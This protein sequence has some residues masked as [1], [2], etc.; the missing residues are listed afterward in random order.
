MAAGPP[1]PVAGAPAGPPLNP[2]VA[3]LLQQQAQA[4]Q[5]RVP[6]Y[7][8]GGA[9]VIEDTEGFSPRAKAKRVR[10]FSD[11]GKP[12]EDLP[13]VE[14]KAKGGSIKKRRPTGK[15]KLGKGEKLPVPMVTDEDMGDPPVP[16]AVAAAPAAPPPG[17]PPA[18]MP[19]M[20]EGGKV[21]DKDCDKMAAGGVAKVRRGFP[22]TLAKPKK[23]AT[24]GAVRGCGA[25]RRG[26]G[27]SGV[28]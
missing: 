7:K 10:Q 8:K 21:E 4:T 20:K 12:A 28:Y 11:V 9:V 15:K 14:K 24:G 16:P 17:P 23:M 26:K 19:P 5:G 13:P 3:A 1:P 22:K 18:P 27:F 2:Q 25:A 6:G